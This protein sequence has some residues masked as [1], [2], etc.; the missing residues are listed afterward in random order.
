ML[1]AKGVILMP[2]KSKKNTSLFYLPTY[3]GGE[4][5][6]S[7]LLHSS[8][9]VERI[10]WRPDEVMIDFVPTKFHVHSRL[11][12]ASQLRTFVFPWTLAANQLMFQSVI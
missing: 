10:L 6:L 1:C 5:K 7:S 9:L 8:P 2:E 4:D 3:V 11:S 12:L